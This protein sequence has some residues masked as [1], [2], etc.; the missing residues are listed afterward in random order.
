[1]LFG[2]ITPQRKPT[3]RG[4]VFVWSLFSGTG[5]ITGRT[6]ET[7][8]CTRKRSSLMEEA[9]GGWEKPRW[10]ESG[11]RHGVVPQSAPLLRCV[12]PHQRD[13]RLFKVL[14]TKGISDKICAL[15]NRTRCFSFTWHWD[16]IRA[17]F[18]AKK[19]I[20]TVFWVFF[21]L[22][23]SQAVSCSHVANAMRYHSKTLR[24]G[25]SWIVSSVF[26]L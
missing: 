18:L 6:V 4:I 2:N 8:H 9:K 15:I 10:D 5:G 22:D 23:S 24:R 25:E 14:S 20:L 16:R 26:P 21:A 17:H 7:Q 12:L 11:E 3:G 19:G 1:M 13:L